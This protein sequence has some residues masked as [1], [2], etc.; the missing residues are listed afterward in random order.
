ME[1]NVERLLNE[2]AEGA[3]E[4]PRPGLAQ[5]IRNRIPHRLIPH[6]DGLDTI[7]VLIDLRINKLT[8]AA[9]III[10][11]VLCANFFGGRDWTED[12][13]HLIRHSLG[14]ISAARSDSLAGGSKYLGFVETGK[15]ITYYGD[16][17]D[18]KDGEA[19]LA[20]WQLPN[21]QYRVVFADFSTK[22]VSAEEVVKLQS[23]MLKK[24]TKR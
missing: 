5:D 22:I 13:M 2:L 17:I 23:R 8:A 21:G 11:I 4:S 14:R 20:H 3:A 18:P 16:S 1:E 24:K 19:I 7:N 9:A 10:T 15:D 6:R 12:G